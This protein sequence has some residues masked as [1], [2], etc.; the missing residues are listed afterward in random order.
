[1]LLT[2]YPLIGQELHF[3]KILHL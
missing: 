1:V 2:T 3:E